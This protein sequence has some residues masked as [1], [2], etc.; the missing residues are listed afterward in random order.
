MKLVSVRY[1]NL[2]TETIA[3]VNLVCTTLYKTEF[4]V[5]SV[6]YINTV[7]ASTYCSI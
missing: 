5:D 3:V 1:W 2:Q 7:Y 4:S 6:D